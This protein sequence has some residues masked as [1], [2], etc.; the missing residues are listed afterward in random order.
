MPIIRIE[1][2]KIFV[3]L[4]TDDARKHIAEHGYDIRVVQTH[5]VYKPDY[6]PLRVL[7]IVEKDIV[8]DA[9]IG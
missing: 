4:S 8:V 1:D 5:L 7:L 2:P 9:T 3:G 6:D